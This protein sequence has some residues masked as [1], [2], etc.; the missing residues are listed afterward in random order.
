MVNCSPPQENFNSTTPSGEL[1]NVLFGKLSFMMIIL[2]SK[3]V[4]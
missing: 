2:F 1:Q 4:Q 3:E